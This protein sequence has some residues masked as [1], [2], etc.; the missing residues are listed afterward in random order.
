MIFLCDF[1][2]WRFK[3]KAPSDDMILHLRGGYFQILKTIKFFHQEIFQAA[4]NN[5]G[6]LSFLDPFW[7]ALIERLTF[8]PVCE[9]FYCPD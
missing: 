9:K 5:K 1:A 3:E 2:T 6:S 4:E 7:L 8:F